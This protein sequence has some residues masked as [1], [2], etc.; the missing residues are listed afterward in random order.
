MGLVA[1]ETRETVVN[2][3]GPA[4]ASAHPEVVQHKTRLPRTG[5]FMQTSMRCHTS[6]GR[7]C[8]YRMMLAR[9]HVADRLSA[10]CLSR[11]AYGIAGYIACTK[12]R[13][14]RSATRSANAQPPPIPCSTLPVPPHTAQRLP[15]TLPVP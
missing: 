15:S 9:K 5:A 13:L 10:Q 12:Y 6:A 14:R 11:S 8:I 1:G 7:V 2:A 3:S 4:A